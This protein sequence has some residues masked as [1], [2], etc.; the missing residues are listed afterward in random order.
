MC[1]CVVCVCESVSY[2]RVTD[3]R[4]DLDPVLREE[5]WGSGVWR[6]CVCVNLLCGCVWVTVRRVDLAPPL[7]EEGGAQMCG[8]NRPRGSGGDQESERRRLP[9]LCVPPPP[10]AAARDQ[11]KTKAFLIGKR[12]LSSKYR[13]HPCVNRSLRQ[14]SL[15]QT[16]PLTRVIFSCFRD[17]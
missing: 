15:Q 11:P 3:R 12:T 7:R 6:L 4:V 2:G 13:I 16:D 9:A 8:D 17:G 5:G 1:V 14:K 10:R